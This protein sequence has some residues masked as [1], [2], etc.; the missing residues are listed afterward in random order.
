M[1]VSK[2]QI[3]DNSTE[4]VSRYLSGLMAADERQAFEAD[5]AADPALAEELALQREMAGLLQGQAR[6]EAR[7]QQLQALGQEYFPAQA[8]LGQRAMLPRR[9]LLW[10]ATAAAAAVVALVLAWPFLFGPSLYEQ[11]AQHPPLALAEKSTDALI[12]WS[13]TEKAFNTGDYATAAKLLEQ[14]LAQQPAD[15][16]ARLY[17]GIAELEMDRYEAARRHFLALS[18]AADPALKDYADWY[19]ALSYLKAGDEARCREVLE[20][21]PAS[22]ALYRTAKEL[23]RKL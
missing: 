9:R 13:A 17:L 7:K 12:D 15:G 11:Y 10:L 16:Q 5:A 18:A 6:R 23:L 22:S 2:P 21:I 8:T 4:R 19:L 14:Y 20:G 1:N 3:M